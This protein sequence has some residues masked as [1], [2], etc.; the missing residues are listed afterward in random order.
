MEFEVFLN[1]SIDLLEKNH[2]FF[3][4]SRIMRV[5]TFNLI[6]ETLEKYTGKAALLLLSRLGELNAEIMLKGKKFV[7]MK[8]KDLLSESIKFG[9]N[10]KWF[11]FD[12]ISYGEEEIIM[13][14]KSTFESKNH[15]RVN[16]S[17]CSFV[18]GLINKISN[19]SKE[20][21][22]CVCEETRCLAKGDEFCEFK[23][24]KI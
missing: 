2:K 22:I 19:S 4:N 8:L 15:S 16:R 6:Q 1:N 3:P 12:S 11:D 13:K 10:H 20:K 7:N 9:S 21:H 18:E 24:K 23:I 14:F 5:E 17:V